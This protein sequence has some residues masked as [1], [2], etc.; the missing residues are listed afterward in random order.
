MF[1]ELTFVFEGS[2]L[3]SENAFDGK[4]LELCPSGSLKTLTKEN[5]EEYIRL[6]LRAYTEQDALQFN[7]LY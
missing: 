7:V 3:A 5:S 2:A 4:T 6:Y 1:G